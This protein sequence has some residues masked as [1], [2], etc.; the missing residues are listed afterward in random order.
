MRKTKFLIA[1]VI[2]CTLTS[3]TNAQ[4][5]KVINNQTT[6]PLSSSYWITNNTSPFSDAGVRLRLHARADNLNAAF[7][8]YWQNLYFRTGNP[9]YGVS[10]CMGQW[11][12]TGFNMKPWDRTVGGYDNWQQKVWVNGRVAADAY[13]QYSDVSMKK[14]ISPITNGLTKVLALNPISYNYR[15][16]VIVGDSLPADSISTNLEEFYRRDT[17]YL[18]Y[19]LTAQELETVCPNLVS[20]LGNKKG[21]NYVELVPVLIKAIQ[22]QQV[23]IQSL[24]QDIENWKGSSIDSTIDQTRLFQNNP[25]PFDGITT[26][27]YYID[28]NT[29]V[30]N[31]LIEI[32]NIMGNLQ[33][34]LTL[35]D[36]SGV[37]QIQ[38]NGSS[39][40]QGYYI[41][42]LKI[43]GSVKDSKMFLKEQ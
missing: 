10:V 20:P 34:S 2:M 9:G 36:Q 4:S 5:L 24:H 43:N 33:S 37:G 38:Y 6:I 41:Y 1:S 3:K 42:T 18:H 17:A 19:G 26:I 39:L 13:L 16:D 28:E 30:T 22:E 7:V 15:G 14:N 40:N 27:S 23:I 21:I 11:G 25:N 32:R 31:A 29:V 12:M 35:S 8:D